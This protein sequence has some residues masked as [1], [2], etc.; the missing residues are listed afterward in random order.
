MEKV[1]LETSRRCR[2]SSTGEFGAAM[3][4]IFQ[5]DAKANFTWAET[6]TLARRTGGGL[7][8]PRRAGELKLH[9]EQ[10]AFPAAKVGY[11][12]RIYID[13]AT[14]GVMSLSI[15]TDDA[16]KALPYPQGGGAGGLRLRGYQRSRLSAAGQRAG[17]H[18]TSQESSITGKLVKRNDIAFSNFREFGSTA[19]IVG[20]GD[21]GRGALALGKLKYISSVFSPGANGGGSGTGRLTTCNECIFY[22]T[23][24]NV[25]RTLLVT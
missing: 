22:F 18:Q 24:C 6:V 21:T 8:L 12:G 7:R 20:A 25:K 9:A 4:S 19:R 1:P 23:L 2:I 16:P 10:S 13:Q 17:D 11:H 3:I 5:P 14:H 15:I